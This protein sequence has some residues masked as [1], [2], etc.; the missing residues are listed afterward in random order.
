MMY[1]TLITQWQ[2]YI[3]KEIRQSLHRLCWKESLCKQ[4]QFCSAL[5]S[6]CALNIRISE[7]KCIVYELTLSSDWCRGKIA[8]VCLS[9]SYYLSTHRGWSAL[10]FEEFLFPCLCLIAQFFTHDCACRCRCRRQIFSFC[11]TCLAF[12]MGL[13]MHCISI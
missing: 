2:Q 9:G 1:W 12:E 13:C 10:V 8:D 6:E 7:C 5:H 3:T 11:A 4:C